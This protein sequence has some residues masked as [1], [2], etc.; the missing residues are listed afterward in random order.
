MSDEPGSSFAPFLWKLRARLREESVGGFVGGWHN[1]AFRLWRQFFPR[2]AAERKL[3]RQL[4]VLDDESRLDHTAGYSVWFARWFSAAEQWRAD[5][6]SGLLHLGMEPINFPVAGMR[7]WI[8]S[9]HWNGQRSDREPHCGCRL[10]D[11]C[12][13]EWHAGVRWQGNR[14]DLYDTRRHGSW[15]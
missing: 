2:S 4:A 8:R 13:G 6:P 3:F 5:R 14:R 7:Q 9:D 1:H 12:A 11:L 15:L 10:A